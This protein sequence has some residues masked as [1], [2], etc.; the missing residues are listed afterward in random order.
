[1]FQKNFFIKFLKH[2][3]LIFLNFDLYNFTSYSNIS[4]VLWFEIYSTWSDSYGLVSLSGLSVLLPL[5]HKV[6]TRWWGQPGHGKAWLGRGAVKLTDGEVI[7]GAWVIGFSQSLKIECGW[8]KSP[9]E[10]CNVKNVWQTFW[11]LQTENHPLTAFS[12]QVGLQQYG[13]Q[14]KWRMESHYVIPASGHTQ[15]FMD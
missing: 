6:A 7:R 11:D 3:I 12:C 10:W 2:F 8:C 9:R 4:Q 5:W 15:R 14:A 1:M 13:S